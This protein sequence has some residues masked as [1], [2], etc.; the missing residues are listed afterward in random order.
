MKSKAL[1]IAVLGRGLIGSAAARHLSKMGHKVLLIGPP[2]P[3]TSYAAHGG[4]FGS[5][6]DE[7]R[8]TRRLELHPYW[9][10]MN[11]ASISRYGEIAAESGID[12]YREVG[13]LHIGAL[14]S[15]DVALIEGIANANGVP[16]ESLEDKAL[17]GRFPFLRTVK[18]MRGVFESSDAGYISPRRL[19][20]AQTVAARRAGA[21]F[22]NEPALGIS[23]CSSGVTIKT[24]SG[25]VTVERVLVTAGGHTPSLLGKTFGFKVLARTAAMF[26]LGESEARR[27]ADMPSMR[28]F[29]P[30]GISQYILPPIAYPDGHV[31]LKLGGDPVDVELEDEA[32][33][34]E[35]FRS[36][37]SYSVA[38]YLQAQILDRIRDLRFEARRVVPC[39]TTFSD[40]GLPQ[41]G[42][43]S[44]HVAVAFGC[45]GK[46]AKCSDEMGR[47]GGMAVLGKTR[48]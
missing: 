21:C 30:S 14:D 34:K 20:Q 3:T 33:I 13:V 45:Q 2:E 39:M 16:Y 31:W 28:Y 10:Q 8:I 23:E 38:D 18:H 42:L 26:R 5:H 22:V 37:G 11:Q 12:F 1:K 40:S 25:S 6:Y 29:G 44:N 36:G 47:L 48:L 17:A 9:M 32:S 41:I 24:K 27:L 19:V 4:V 46:S 35:W 7:G 43:I 15:P